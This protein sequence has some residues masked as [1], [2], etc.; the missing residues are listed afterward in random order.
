METTRWAEGAKMGAEATVVSAGRRLGISWGGVG[1][2]LSPSVRDL[3][4]LSSPLRNTCSSLLDSPF[5]SPCLLLLPVSLHRNFGS[6][7]AND[8]RGLPRPRRKGF[9][10]HALTI[11]GR[12]LRIRTP[13]IPLG[14]GSR[15]FRKNLFLLS[16]S[17]TRDAVRL[18]ILLGLVRT[19]KQKA[20]A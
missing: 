18:N 20:R 11:L 2:L 15:S 6:H 19:L 17:F 16:P 12:Y 7:W 3:R 4:V 14:F 13:T 5:H 8:S 9:F 10:S 1:R